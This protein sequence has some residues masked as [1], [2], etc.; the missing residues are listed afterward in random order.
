MS[1]KAF[2]EIQTILTPQQRTDLR[3]IYNPDFLWGANIGSRLPS[4]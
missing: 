3:R 2:A 1:E 4:P